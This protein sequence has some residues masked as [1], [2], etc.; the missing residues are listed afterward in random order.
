MSKI[1]SIVLATATCVACA[2]STSSSSWPV[3]GSRDPAQNVYPQWRW[4][5]DKLRDVGDSTA[6]PVDE[7]HYVT[8]RDGH[9]FALA[10]D[11]TTAPC[12]VGFVD[13]TVGIDF[14]A[15]RGTQVWIPWIGADGLGVVAGAGHDHMRMTDAHTLPRAL[16][17]EAVGAP[18]LRA[19]GDCYPPSGANGYDSVVGV[20]IGPT[21]IATLDDIYALPDVRPWPNLDFAENHSS[22]GRDGQPFDRL[23]EVLR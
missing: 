6:W 15:T 11:E 8:A 22:L 2:C 13:T 5:P 20:V 16:P 9:L 3:L 12:P 14:R 21:S 18:V 10:T 19:C 4:C 17:P 23:P 1:S 7:H